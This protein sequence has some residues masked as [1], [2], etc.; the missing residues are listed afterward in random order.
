[1]AGLL[2]VDGGIQIDDA[3]VPLGELVNFHCRAM[4]NLP[5]KAPQQLLPDDFCHHLTLR[6]VGGDVLREQEGAFHRVLLAHSQQILH[7]VAGL[8]RNGHDCLEIRLLGIN[9]DNFQQLFLFHG[10]NLVDGKHHRAMVC[11]D[12]L[13]QSFLLGPQ[14]SNW[15]HHQNGHIHIGNGFL[16]HIHHVVAQLGA[17]AMIAGGIHKDELGIVRGDNAPDAVAGG[18]GFIGYDCNFLPHQ[19]IGQGGLSHIGAA[20]NGNHGGLCFHCISPVISVVIRIARRVPFIRVL[21]KIRG[22]G[23]L[24]AAPTVQMGK[25]VPFDRPLKHESACIR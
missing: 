11:L 23:R 14:G 24:L 8:G 15:L 7:T 22:F 6:L 3:V 17:G 18:L 1:M 21:A 4:G 5:V 10:V 25:L 13:E 2:A 19:E 16:G 12:F 9:A 20:C